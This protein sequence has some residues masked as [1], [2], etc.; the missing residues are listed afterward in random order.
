MNVVFTI[1]LSAL[2]YISVKA[3]PPE[4]CFA[5]FN[6]A[7][8][9]RPPTPVI[10]YWKPGSRCEVAM[11]RGCLPN[12]NMF[13][14]EYDC[15]STCIFTARARPEDYHQQN[16]IDA[17]LDIPTI[18]P[19]FVGSTTTGGDIGNSTATGNRI[20]TTVTGDVANSTGAEGNAGGGADAG[21][22]PTTVAGD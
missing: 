6:W 13:D 15:V 7:D 16:E 9:G 10:Y 17:D 19:G 11:W 18:M 5:E 8:C 1:F 4:A 3:V 2:I 12:M 20:A 14:N 21:T 22:A